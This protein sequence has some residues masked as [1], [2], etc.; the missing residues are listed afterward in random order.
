MGHRLVLHLLCFGAAH[1]RALDVLPERC[2]C[3]SPYDPVPAAFVS[4]S[5]DDD[6]DDDDD[7]DGS[8]ERRSSLAVLFARRVE[9]QRCDLRSY[10]DVSRGLAGVDA[11]LHVA[12]FG[13]SGK[14]MLN[15]TMVTAVNVGGT[16]NVLRAA[17][18]HGVS[19]VC[20]TSTTNVCFGGRPLVHKD[21]TLPYL[22][23]DEHIDYYSRTKC[24]A[25]QLI[26]RANGA[27]LRQQQSQQHPQHKR[28]KQ[29]HRQ[30][31][32]QHDQREQQ[33]QQQQQHQQQQSGH[34]SLRTCAIRPAGIYGEGEQRHL[35]RIV[36]LMRKGMF[37]F[38]IGQSD[39]LVEFVYVDNLVDAHILAVDKLLRASTEDSS[40]SGDG[41]ADPLPHD[42]AG[43]AFFVSD[44][45]PINNFEF[46]RPL[47]EG[48]GYRFP[49]LRL[50]T[51]LVYYTALV[52]EVS[53]LAHSS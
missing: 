4:R 34:R 43:Q 7:A 32:Q 10:S 27:P 33:Q 39:S 25:E 21:E 38:T 20:Y 36:G 44:G 14:D 3:A 42:V 9:Y 28:G 31:Q 29:Q 24:I 19:V 1:V 48:L 22:R 46:F 26:I 18:E 5:N 16:E 45:Q 17:I 53:R 50:P 8:D 15:R 23:D 11:V 37:C 13:M 41:G 2:F 6:D 51:V 47:L 49:M 30:Q 12:S 52:I 40:H 35:P